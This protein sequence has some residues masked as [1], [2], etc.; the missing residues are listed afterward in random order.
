M[1]ASWT[2]LLAASI[3]APQGRDAPKLRV[4]G[5]PAVRLQWT[6]IIASPE[7]DWINDL[8]L[9]RNG[10]IAAAGFLNRRGDPRSDWR[11]VDAEI[12]T[13]GSLVRQDNYGEGSGVDAIFGM[14]ETG[15]GRRV[16]A[17]FT[18]RIG[19]GGIDGLSMTTGADGPP[20]GEEPH[21]GGGYDRFTNVAEAA[22][23][24]VFLGHSQAEHSDKRRVFVV[25]TDKE[26]RK[27]W[28]RVHDAPESHGALYIDAHPDGGFIV[29]GGTRSGDN[30]DMFAMKVDAG[31]RGLRRKPA[32]RHFGGAGRMSG[33]PGLT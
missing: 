33:S 12:G 13:D 3:A 1:T 31:G 21:G 24:Y 27:L 10:N 18:T 15:D 17:G 22:D 8:V 28:E 32:G 9:L 6:R 25:K 30:A 11:A 5:D 19:N 14:L 2:I 26:G 7:N 20:V 16:L 23:G 29:A 4:S